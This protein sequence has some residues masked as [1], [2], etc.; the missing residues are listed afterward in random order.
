MTEAPVPSRGFRN[1]GWN[2]IGGAWNG[3]MSVVAT[4]CYVALLGLEGYSLI[5]FWV[6]MQG[7][8][9][10]CD[11]GL[12]SAL[13]KEFADPASRGEDRSG[14]VGLLRTLDRV[15]WPM[16]G[17]MA[18]SFYFAADG[19]AAHWLNLRA[20]QE[21]QVAPALRMLGLAL[22]LQFPCAL[23]SSGLSGLQK[24][25]IANAVQVV[26]STLRYG[27]GVAILLWRV[28]LFWF[29][30]A[31]ALVSGAQ[32]VAT[33][34]ALTRL[35]AREG[36]GTSAVRFSWLRRLWRFSAG[37]AATTI[38]AVL[39]AH[40]DRF[41]LS[42][43]APAEELGKYA[44]AFTASGVLQL[45]IQPFYR[46]YFPRFSELLATDATARLREEY[47]QSCRALAAFV[48]PAALVGVAFAPSLFKTWVGNADETTVSVF[49]WLLLGVASSGLM[50]LP[51]AFQH[52]HGWTRLH[53]LM[54]AGNLVLGLPAMIWAIRQWGARGA[55]CLWVLHGV[56]D[57][58]LGLWL[59]HRR[60]LP[61][62][63]L[64]WLGSVVLPPLA[65]SAPIVGLS[66]WLM[67][68]QLPA[69]ARVLWLAVTGLLAVAG[70]LLTFSARSKARAPA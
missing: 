15:Y 4:P 14:R 59:M 33:R 25:G 10:V 65:W 39:L 3:V 5:G 43:M 1:V 6:L 66:W 64:P 51:A 18:L 26:F 2:F 48:L 17:L 56:S 44:L 30:S 29:F 36:Q 40:A 35:L 37:M 32:A 13:V 38:A 46:V 8:L 9:A 67:P 34:L 27:V 22:G 53:A 62:E 19:I 70:P 49:R 47:Y 60:L 23:Y 57:L 12:G 69:W 52:A 42:L 21:D 58:T 61:G 28:D 16:A 45:G 20:L 24:H 41:L 55:T 50:W 63:Y 7:L 11:L 54:V 31:Q 68:P